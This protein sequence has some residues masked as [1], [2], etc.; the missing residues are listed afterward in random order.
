VDQAT[1]AAYEAGARTWRERGTARFLERVDGFRA[2][3]PTGAV[4]ADLGC[5]AGFHLPH[6]PEPVVGLDVSRA[7]LGLAREAAPGTPLV[8]AELAHLPF[9]RG[10][11]G[12]GWARGS[13]VHVPRVELPWALMELHHATAVDAPVH[14]SMLRGDTE[15]AFAEDP[16]PGRFFARW[17]PEALR[18]VVEGAGFDVGEL[19]LDDGDDRW[20][21]VLAARARALPDTVGPGMRLVLCGLNPSIYAADAGVGFARPGNRFWPA[22]LA[23]GIVTRDRDPRH[24]LTHHGIGMTDLV[25]RATNRADELSR[26]EYRQ[27]ADR[28]ER[29]VEWLRPGAVCFVGLGGYREARDR[30]AVAGVQPTPFGGVPAYVM[31]NPSGLNAHTSPADLAEHLR[32]A[33]RLADDSLMDQ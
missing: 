27:G 14:L 19:A 23:A 20:V 11:L 16:L 32:A 29:L 13:Y 10:A 18:R 9:R 22:A 4:T 12:G 33:A 3:T 17:Q 31:P 7:M 21:H 2:R 25:K 24:A 5:G 6:L 26:D 28:V 15:G 30:N 8:R 1:V